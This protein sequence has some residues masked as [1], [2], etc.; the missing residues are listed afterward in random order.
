MNKIIGI[1]FASLILQGCDWGLG[2]N[3]EST[4][5]T[6]YVDYYQEAC[7]HNSTDMCFRLRKNTN[8]AFTL[9]LVDNTGFDSLEWGKRYTVQVEVD[10]D[11]AGADSMYRLISVDSEEIVDAATNNFVLTFNMSSQILLDN[12]NNSWV[13]AGQDVFS[14]VESDCVLLTNSYNANEKIQL[15]FSAQDDQLTLLEVLCSAAENDFS[16]NC[17]G[18]NRSN[19]DIAQYQSDCGLSEPK[20]CLIY[21]E[22]DTA[23]NAWHIFP[24]EITDFSANWGTAYDIQV[25]VTSSGGSVRSAQWLQ[26]NSTEDLTD[27]EFNVV[28]RTGVQGLKKSNS[29]IINYSGI[30]FN[31]E[32]YVQC[33]SIN[34]AI[35]RA[36]TESE[37]FI[38]LLTEIELVNDETTLIIKS[39][40]CDETYGDFKEN[41]LDINEDIIWF[42]NP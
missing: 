21:R 19:W 20:L 23:N 32:R 22:N 12:L 41:C 42:E 16:A 6:L 8:D 33:D 30:E 9:S 28:M 7:S 26:E 5:E 2:P 4:S 27:S 34:K 25:E 36:D 38:A 18:L 37:R 10:Y 35:E 40:T 24:F 29:G 11:S 15:K 14:C 31:C 39:I 13:I 3:Y 17:E 1:L